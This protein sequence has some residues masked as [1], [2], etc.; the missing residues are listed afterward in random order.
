VFGVLVE[1]SLNT[2]NGGRSGLEV[3]EGETDAIGE[4][5]TDG[6]IVPF[7]VVAESVAVKDGAD[8]TR[9]PLIEL[10]GDG[11]EHK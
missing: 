11:G 7:V 2:V 4:E 6:D 10:L 5:V 8:G 1:A 9:L 3:T